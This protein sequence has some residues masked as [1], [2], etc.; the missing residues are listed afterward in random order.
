MG[1]FVD[2]WHYPAELLRR[3]AQAVEALGCVIT[4]NHEGIIAANYVMPQNDF[5]YRT[6]R[7]Q[8]FQIEIWSIAADW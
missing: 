1:Q 7:T 6:R 3:Y 4:V 5:I 2:L 8:C